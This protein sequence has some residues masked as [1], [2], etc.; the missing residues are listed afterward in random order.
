MDASRLQRA[1]DRLGVI[2]QPLETITAGS[3]RIIASPVPDRQDLVAPPV[4]AVLTFRSVVEAAFSAGPVVPLRFGTVAKS[5]EH[6]ASLVREKEMTYSDLL[7]RLEGC[8]E[9]GVSVEREEA[10][11]GTREGSGLSA[12]QRPGT[13]YLRR[14]QQQRARERAQVEAVALPL[15]HAVAE[16][17]TD[18]TLSAPM[19]SEGRVSLAFLIP[20]G[21]VKRFR[22]TVGRVQVPGTSSIEI[23]GPWAP[24]SFV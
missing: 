11:A 18:V 15:Q 9:M 13:T 22:Q 6:A 23:V 16:R 24:Y 8:V 7:P 12:E 5:P 2:E 19:V 4:D 14:K 1:T 20:R 17:I 21:Q 3:L 10:E